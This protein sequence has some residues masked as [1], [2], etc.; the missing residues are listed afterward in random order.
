[1]LGCWCVCSE[2]IKVQDHSGRATTFYIRDRLDQGGFSTIELASPTQSRQ[3]FVLKRI[4]CH[5]KAD[6]EKALREAHLHL[7][8]PSHPNLLPCF[9]IARKALLG[10][11]Q[12][13]LSE[14]YLIL[15]YAKQGTL[16]RYLD[17]SRIRANSIPDR[18][19]T[20]LMLGI[21]E[22]LL[23]LLSLHMPLAHRFEAGKRVIAWHLVPSSHGFR[24]MYTG[25][26]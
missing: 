25:G 5:S 12:G 22:G 1:M 13:A 18:Q 8:L 15:Q 10:H 24:L 23:A 20:R 16:Q 9:G 3:L 17:Q 26:N 4:I 14:V 7:N 11:P 21:C 2:K 19:V 6:E